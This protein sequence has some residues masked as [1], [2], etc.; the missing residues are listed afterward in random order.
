MKLKDKVKNILAVVSLYL[1]IIVG[2]ILVNARFET[3]NEQT[4]SANEPRIQIAQIS[5]VN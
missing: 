1:V 4:K 2:V 5:E 3:I